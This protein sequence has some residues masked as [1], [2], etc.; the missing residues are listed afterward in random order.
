MTGSVSGASLDLAGCGADLHDGDLQVLG[1]AALEGDVELD[2][3]ADDPSDVLAYV[4]E[5]TDATREQAEACLAIEEEF[6]AAVGIIYSPVGEEW[7]F[8]YYSEAERA[9]LTDRGTVVDTLL[10]ARDCVRLA[11]V[12]EEIAHAVYIAETEYVS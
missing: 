10:L 4:L 8:R 6:M 9:T 11:G 2:G 3:V 7:P 5:H 12:P 1:S